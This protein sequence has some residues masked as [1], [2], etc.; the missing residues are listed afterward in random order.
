VNAVI[1]HIFL[2]LVLLTPAGIR[3]QQ[4]EP[5]DLPAYTAL[6]REAAAA[7]RRNDRLGLDDAGARLAAVTVVRVGDEMLPADNRW[8]AEELA[9]PAPRTALIATRLA[10]LAD[11]LALPPGAAPPDAR[12][13]L[14]AILARP[15]FGEST[16]QTPQW[17]T[18]FWNWVGRVLEAL[19][20]PLTNVQPA[21]GTTTA[22]VVAAIGVLLLVGI[23]L[24]LFL[25]LR[26]SLV[27]GAQIQAADVEDGLT[28]REASDQAG[29]LIR[30]GDYR[31]AVRS[32]YLAA[33]LW[34]DERGALRYDRA[35]TNREH[36][37]R[38]RDNPELRGRLAPIIATFDNV[39]YGHAPITPDELATYRAQVEAL[40]R[41][42]SA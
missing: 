26:R 7:A 23:G 30:S 42:G 12:E 2:A 8:L 13:R 29:E 18:D 27:R 33:L 37:E 25:G 38:L 39:W 15:P 36:L 3:A 35:L 40:R 21:A 20:R 14:R 41:E 10:A 5:P 17:W 16:A 31:A 6:V 34:L 22:L 4:P 9:R 32:L 11:A 24:Y 28:A 1:C 19:L